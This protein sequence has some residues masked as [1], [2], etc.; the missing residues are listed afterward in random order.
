MTKKKKRI[1]QQEKDKKINK[2][3]LTSKNP[4]YLK[5]NIPTIMS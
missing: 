1:K 3:N 2:Y 4:Y 5:L